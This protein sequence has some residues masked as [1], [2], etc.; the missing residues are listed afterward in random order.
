MLPD[1]LKDI[2]FSKNFRQA[3]YGILSITRVDISRE[4][5]QKLVR[6]GIAEVIDCE[7]PFHGTRVEISHSRSRIFYKETG[8]VDVAH[9]VP[10]RRLF[11]AGPKPPPYSVTREEYQRS[12]DLG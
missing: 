11:F 6:I 8:F 2:R 7:E 3:L 9:L 12:T 5:F 1:A 10:C 4:S